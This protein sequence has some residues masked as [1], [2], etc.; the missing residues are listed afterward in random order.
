L[1]RSLSD[2]PYISELPFS[3]LVAVLAPFALWFALLLAGEMG[4]LYP[5]RQDQAWDVS[6]RR[7]LAQGVTGLDD[8]TVISLERTGCFGWC[9]AYR[10]SL[11]GSGRVEYVG[12][13]YVCEFGPRTATADPREIRRLLDAMLAAEF[14]ALSS[15]QGWPVPD[16]PIFSTTLL[17]N[18]RISAVRHFGD[19]PRWLTAMEDEIDR[20]ADTEQWLPM[21]VRPWEPYCLTTDGQLRKLTMHDPATEAP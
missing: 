5:S 3:T 7:P 8:S 10:V 9:P 15:D 1:E 2:S 12:K 11:Y 21:L 4:I 6:S 13:Q 17:H 19:G 14:D 20:I 16:R 18:G